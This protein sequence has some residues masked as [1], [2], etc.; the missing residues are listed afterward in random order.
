MIVRIYFTEITDFCIIL[1]TGYELQPAIPSFFG[2]TVPA[3]AF[4]N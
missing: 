4:R 3:G 1:T 2:K